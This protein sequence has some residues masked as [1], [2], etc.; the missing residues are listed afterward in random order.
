M[1]GT[2]FTVP[3]MRCMLSNWLQ[4]PLRKKVLIVKTL[5]LVALVRLGLSL[6]S[7]KRMRL[8]LSRAAK[9][10]RDRRPVDDQFIQDIPW[11][12]SVVAQRMLADGPCLTQALAVQFLFD[13]RE[14]PTELK[15][16]V[17][18]GSQGELIAHAWLES[19]GQ[20]LIGG[21]PESLARYAPLVS[22][23]GYPL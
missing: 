10:L 21:T 5:L 19:Q 11:A 7:F 22:I 23:E 20:I 9:F 17:L 13:R 15:I 18:K 4:V 3:G 14:Y 6:L 8:A 2:M 12:V 1:T 16:G